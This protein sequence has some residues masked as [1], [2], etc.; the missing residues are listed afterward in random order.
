MERTVIQE[1]GDFCAVSVAGF[2]CTDTR[3]FSSINVV[4]SMYLA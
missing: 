4:G 3:E 1:L 2:V